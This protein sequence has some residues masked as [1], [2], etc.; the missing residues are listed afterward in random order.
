MERTISKAG[1]SGGLLPVALVSTGYESIYD[2]SG[3]YAAWTESWLVTR[4]VKRFGIW[5]AALC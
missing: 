2:A 4:Y 1:T 5:N 3:G